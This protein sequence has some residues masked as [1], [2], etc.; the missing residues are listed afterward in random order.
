M[1]GATIPTS[2][3]YGNIGGNQVKGVELAV[4]HANEDGDV[5][6]TEVEVE[7]R[8][9]QTDTQ[10][11][12]Q[13]ARELLQ[14]QN[15]D[16]LAGNFSSSVALAIG[17]LAQ[18]EDVIY[19]CVGGSNAITGGD[20]RSNVFNA[21]NSAVQQTSGGL[22]YV[23]DEGLGES[24]YE[25]SA[26]YSWG[27][28]IQNWNENQ[29]VASYDDVEYLGNSFVEFG[30]TDYSQAITDARNSGAD[31]IS[32]NLFASNHVQSA[33]QANEFD[34][35]DDFVC[36]WPATGIIEAEQIG[37]DVLSND[38]FY[39]SA[40]WYWQHD[41]EGAQEFADAFQSEYGERPLGFSA[42]MYAGVRTTL[43]A[44]D[45]AGGTETADIRNQMEDRE[46]FPQL[47]GV[48]ERFRACDHRAS[49]S[50]MTVQGRDPSEV[51]GQNFYEIINVPQNP[52][53]TQMRTCDQ[54][55]CS[56]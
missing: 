35:F 11:A 10:E 3:P 5:S 1:I 53:E 40:P 9:T 4:Q 50:T 19:T 39:A 29:I 43:K 41:A 38:N 34:L 15:A 46:L 24:V 37:P 23:L 17:E 7:F 20:C 8:D 2:G 28:S 47:W 55:G 30:A 48:G 51:D 49:I 42:S 6:D 14:R 12:T 44:I 31:I 13:V 27:Q 22:K 56:F 33:R 18:R 36:V 25:I 26:D 52:E 45:A 21:G 54:T 32:F 16:F